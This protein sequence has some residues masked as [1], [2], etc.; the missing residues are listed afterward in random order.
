MSSRCSKV[1]SAERLEIPYLL[2]IEGIPRV[3]E[4]RSRVHSRSCLRHLQSHVVILCDCAAYDGFAYFNNWSFR[5]FRLS[6]ANCVAPIIVHSKRTSFMSAQQSSTDTQQWELEP[7]S[8]Y[9]FE[10]D[11]GASLAIKVHLHF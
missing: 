8:E 11:P 6:L 1:Y 9:R 4:S 5:A 2:N 3:C 7:E 10:L